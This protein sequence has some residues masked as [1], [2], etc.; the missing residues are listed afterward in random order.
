MTVMENILPQLAK[1]KTFTG[2]DV[3]SGYWHLLLDSE[4]NHLTTF[5]TPKGRYRCIRLLFG[6]SVAAD[7]FQENLEEVL[8]GREDTAQIVDDSILWGNGDSQAETQQ[9][10]DFDLESL[11]QKVTAANVYLKADKLKYKCQKV[12]F[13][14]HL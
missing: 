6:V 2:I 4:S 14:G 1:A 12:K 8:A 11:M 9:R 3:K 10:H 7:I 13:A 5:A